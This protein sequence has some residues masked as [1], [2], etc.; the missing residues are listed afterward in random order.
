MEGRRTKADV[1]I[2]EETLQVRENDLCYRLEPVRQK[3][4][5][6]YQLERKAFIDR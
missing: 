4:E 3:L 5:A 2:L 1:Q 6:M